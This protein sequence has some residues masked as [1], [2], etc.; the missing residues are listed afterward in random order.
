MTQTT[1][2]QT[3]DG[4]TVTATMSVACSVY[5]DESR[6][7]GDLVSTKRVP[8][9]DK[10][11]VITIGDTIMGQGEEL[12]TWIPKNAP[13]GYSRMLGKMFIPDAQVAI[14]EQAMV[15]LTIATQAEACEEY[16]QLESQRLATI[17]RNQQ[18]A[19]INAREEEQEYRSRRANGYCPKCGSYCYGDCQS[20]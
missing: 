11:I 2:W 17:E 1:Q 18:R 19:E 14:I 3:R 16:Q 9:T 5:T 6:L 15:D 20:N 12:G 8:Y 7:D 10:Q 4:R 13:V